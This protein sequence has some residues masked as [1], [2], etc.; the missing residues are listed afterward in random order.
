MEEFPSVLKTRAD[1]ARAGGNNDLSVRMR[2]FAEIASE[3]IGPHNPPSRADAAQSTQSSIAPVTGNTTAPVRDMSPPPS[4]AEQRTVESAAGSGGRQI[5][6][7]PPTAARL[8]AV[9]PAASLGGSAAEPEPVKAPPLSA[10]MVDALFKQGKA[11]LEIGDVSAARRLLARAAESGSGEAALAL[12]D[13][14]NAAFLREHG[15]V[16]L[17]ANQELAKAWYRKAIGFGES[18]ARARL[19]GLDDSTQAAAQRS[20]TTR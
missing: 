2:A 6:A 7:L 18:R 19:A 3:V 13:T 4:V 14:Y 17:Q 8:P 9:A 10:A 15:V 1:V 20:M 5:A 12:G 16:G 11:M